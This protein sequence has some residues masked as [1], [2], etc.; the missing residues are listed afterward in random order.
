MHRDFVGVLEVAADRHAHRDPRH[1]D[2]E[3]LQQPREIDRGRLAF[4]VGVG[5]E[6]DL[7]DAVADARRA[8]P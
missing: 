1:L 4:D 2:A 3:R 8:A 6:D 7:V 5:R